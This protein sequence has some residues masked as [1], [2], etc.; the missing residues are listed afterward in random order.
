M[1]PLF[2]YLKNC[3]KFFIV[4]VVVQFGRAEC[5]R[6]EG[7]RVNILPSMCGYDGR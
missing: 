3:E 2:E 7:N 5:P 6:V 4:Y 1:T